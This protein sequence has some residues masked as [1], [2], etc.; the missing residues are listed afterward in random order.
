MRNEIIVEEDSKRVEVAAVV[1]N[2]IIES[3]QIDSAAV[4]AEAA[5]QYAEEHADDLPGSRLGP[6]D[7]PRRILASGKSHPACGTGTT[8]CEIKAAIAYSF[9]RDIK[10]DHSPEDAARIL[11]GTNHGGGGSGL[12]A[13]YTR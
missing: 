13:D 4:L 12:L 6:S 1:I 5:K 2:D 9:V 3:L 11:F 10:K 7:Y 8:S